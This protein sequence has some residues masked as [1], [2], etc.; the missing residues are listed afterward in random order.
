MRKSG[1]HSTSF[2]SMNNNFNPGNPPVQANQVN[3]PD[4]NLNAIINPDQNLEN[5]QLVMWEEDTT[6]TNFDV[7]D[8]TS[9]T[10]KE[11]FPWFVDDKG[12]YLNPDKFL[13]LED[14]LSGLKRYLET[15]VQNHPQDKI[16]EPKLL[17]LIEPYIQQSEDGSGLVKM[18]LRGLYDLIE[19]QLKSNPDSF[20]VLP[21]VS[22]ELLAAI[23]N[24]NT[25]RSYLSLE[26]WFDYV[27]SK[28]EQLNGGSAY[29]DLKAELA[30]T[31]EQLAVSNLQ[32]AE[33]TAKFVDT[34]AQVSTLE[35]EIILGQS[36]S[37]AAAASKPFLDMTI[38]EVSL[39]LMNLDW[40]A[41]VEQAR[42]VV[43]VAPLPLKIITFSLTVRTFVNHVYYR[44]F[45]S[46]I[47]NKGPLAVQE[48][49]MRRKELGL[50]LLLGAPLSMIA[51][52]QAHMSLKGLFKIET[53]IPSLPTTSAKETVENISILILF[54]NISK[55]VPEPV[56]IFIGFYLLLFLILKILG[57]PGIL[58]IT[59]EDKYMRWL[60]IS[61]CLLAIFYQTL[62]LWLVHMF[63]CKKIKISSVW[64][65]SIINWLKYLEAVSKSKPLLV[66]F[67]QRRYIQIVLYLCI[68]L[69][70]CL[71]I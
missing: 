49:A 63:I 9:T 34:Q 47:P 48:W 54:K 15:F 26:N 10:I 25:T 68:M 58:D 62:N 24:T 53:A 59:T 3:N 7:I 55:K 28:L 35:Q 4:V 17:K 5:M 52:H 69:L 18:N 61:L 46:A 2:C 19:G 60:G 44:P 65:D 42:I 51:A 66:W 32:L 70:Y 64:P 22:E 20:K 33:T 50:F 57:L 36:I 12:N 45:P 38:R 27:I 16:S 39:T 29:A 14:T 21:N 71:L 67:K 13:P 11:S 8:S 43:D 37:P 31:Q 41:I 23:Q 1:F 40:N 6:A 30:K 56:K